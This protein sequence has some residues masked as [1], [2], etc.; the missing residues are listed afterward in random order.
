[1]NNDYL[2]KTIEINCPFCNTVHLIEQRKRLTQS[3]V[4]GEVVDYEECYFLCPLTKEEENEF[5][6]SG[7]MDENLLR[8]RDSYRRKKGLLTSSEIIEIRNI[9]GLSQSDFSTLLG[10]GEVTVNRYESKVVQDETYDNIM[11]MVLENPMFALERIDKHKDRFSVDRYEKIRKNITHRVEISGKAYLKKQEIISQYV[12]YEHETDL[13]GYKVLDIEKVANVIGYFAQFVD[14]LYKVK[15]MKL[16]WYSDAIFFDRYGKSMTGLVYRHMPLGALPISY[17]EII[18][19]PTVRVLEDIIC[20]D[21]SYKICPNDNVNLSDFS[22]EE[23]SVLQIVATTFRTFNSKE[24]IDYMHK[25]RAYIETMPNQII[26]YSAAMK[27][28]DLK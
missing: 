23:L 11:R 15:L 19:L 8:A 7:I 26:P 21:I 6:P 4:K 3:I 22:L 20:D 9:Y 28:N 16:L 2:I 27:L 13:N 24:I 12:N 25:E 5:I 18:H 10:W 1:M 17:D 14:N